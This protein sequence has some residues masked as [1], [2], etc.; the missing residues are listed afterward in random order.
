MSKWK[1]DQKEFPVKL[2]YDD[3]RGCIAIIPKPILEKL[4]LPKLLQFE[5]KRNGK[6]DVVGT[7]E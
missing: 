7:N 3:R 1:A 6:I 4:E 2:H 5:I